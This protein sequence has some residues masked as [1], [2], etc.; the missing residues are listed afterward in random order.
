MAADRASL[1]DIPTS[2]IKPGPAEHESSGY[3]YWQEFK[4][5]IDLLLVESTLPPRHE[6]GDELEWP[7]TMAGSL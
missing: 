4:A 1:E 5:Y 3:I 2:A 7:G 6:A